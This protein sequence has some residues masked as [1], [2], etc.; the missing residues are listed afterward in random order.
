[1][2][3][4][5]ALVALFFTCFGSIS[6]KKFI[7]WSFAPVE[8]ADLNPKTRE[9][10]F[11]A[12]GSAQRQ[13]NDNWILNVSIGNLDKAS[14]KEIAIKGEEFYPIF[15]DGEAGCEITW[16]VPMERWKDAKPFDLRIMLNDANKELAINVKHP[17]NE[18]RYTAFG[19]VWAVPLI[20]V[21]SLLPAT[22]FFFISA[23]TPS[24]APPRH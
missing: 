7:E 8:Q 21:E 17:I 19:Y 23:M 3:K 9:K 2:H 12:A 1:M 6:C 18:L 5:I 14:V 4:R 22:P 15:S 13:Y 24:K 11:K 20:V 10:A 16:E